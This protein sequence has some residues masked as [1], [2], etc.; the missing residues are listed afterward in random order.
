MLETILSE[1]LTITIPYLYA[2]I[3]LAIG[4]AIGLFAFI[5]SILTESK[6]DGVSFF[7][8]PISIYLEGFFILILIVT[9]WP[10]GLIF[11]IIL[12]FC[13]KKEY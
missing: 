13:T 6:W 8:L 9:C 11:W 2:V 12:T 10:I 5:D 1:S 3:Y 7:A 4:T